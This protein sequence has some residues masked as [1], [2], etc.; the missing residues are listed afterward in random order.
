MSILMLI[1][2]WIVSG[3][4]GAGFSYAYFQGQFNYPDLAAESRREDAGSSL[5]MGLIFGPMFLVAAFFLSGFG[6]Y[7]WWRWGR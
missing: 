2:A 7:G 6:K 1:A 3:V 5:F 4:I